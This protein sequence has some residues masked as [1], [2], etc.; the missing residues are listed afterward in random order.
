ME[1]V[2][3]TI[4]KKNNINNNR[5]R[6]IVLV[7]FPIEDLVPH[8]LTGATN[9]D[10]YHHNATVGFILQLDKHLTASNDVTRKYRC[11]L[12]IKSDEVVYRLDSW[13]PALPKWVHTASR[14]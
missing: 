2:L 11:R 8:H 13:C 10:V 6:L 4:R 3:V 14:A 9:Q 5:F 12:A 7:L 1:R